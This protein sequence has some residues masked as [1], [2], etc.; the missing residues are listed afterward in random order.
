[1]CSKILLQSAFN[2]P[3]PTYAETS[4]QAQHSQTTHTTTMFPW[5]RLQKSGGRRS[6]WCHMWVRNNKWEQ[7]QHGR[8]AAGSTSVQIT[9][10]TPKCDTHTSHLSHVTPVQMW[11]YMH[12]TSRACH[13]VADTCAKVSLAEYTY[14]E[15]AS[16][17]SLTRQQFSGD[18]HAVRVWD[19]EE[20]SVEQSA[21]AEC[22]TCIW[23][24]CMCA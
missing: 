1:M 17:A 24:D 8:I 15:L 3:S 6:Q 4:W 20:K 19:T 12:V 2:I 7:H 21:R 14:F 23:P 11:H 5:L 18:T 13:G 16:L 22:P 9:D 10:I